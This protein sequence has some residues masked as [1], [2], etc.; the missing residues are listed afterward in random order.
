M[1]ISVNDALQQGIAAHRL[2]NLQEAERYYRLVIQ[3]QPLHPDANHNLGVLAVSVNRTEAAIPFFKSALKGD[4]KIEQFWV[5]YIDALI[6]L[7]RISEAETLLT[8][9]KL[10]GIKSKKLKLSRLKLTELTNY[11]HHLQTALSK[12]QV[13]HKRGR[14]NEAFIFSLQ[15][16]KRFP[17]DINILNTLGENFILNHDYIVAI[18]K[19]KKS[20][21]NISRSVQRLFLNWHCALFNP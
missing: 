14:F 16:E 20:N 7:N 12:L 21:P 9:A 19:F 17:F 15:L 8:Q 4:P 13:L 3:V 5:S 18:K 2:G 6:I 10:D 1:Q 11:L